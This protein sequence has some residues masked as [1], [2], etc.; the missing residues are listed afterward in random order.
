VSAA[1][2]TV[3]RH[4]FEPERTWRVDEAGLSWQGEGVCGHFPF[5][6]ITTIR[7]LFGASRA[8][9]NRYLCQVTRFNGWM[10]EIVSTH[11]A[12]PMNFE[13]RRSTFRP[14]AEQL[15]IQAARANPKIRFWAGVAPLNFWLSGL[16]V[17]SV[18]AL[19]AF[20]LLTLGPGGGWIV[21]AKLVLL[22]FMIPM[23]VRWFR[24]NRPV[25]FTPPAI[26]PGVLPGA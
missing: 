8:D 11:Y 23:V 10:E 15:T 12:G 19:L 1:T 3:R 17:V 13:D 26:P 20:V 25:S 24:R 9:Q 16:L 6:E 2:Y 21:A 22:V 14:F 5:S 4:A 7:L 18:A